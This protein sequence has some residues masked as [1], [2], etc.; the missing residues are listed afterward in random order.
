MKLNLT[1][2]QEM[3]KKTAR[4][5]LSDKCP[6]T[7]V[8]QMEESETGYSIELWQEMAELGWMGLVF[9][10]KYGGGDM[11]F[12]DLAVL[13]EEMG[14]ACLPGPFFSTVVLGGLPILD[15]GNED[16]TWLSKLRCRFSHS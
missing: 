1:E 14:R 8:T 10:E 2:E 12:L 13:L 4:D 11:N 6:K 5:F 9:P 7:F 15:L 3:I 16:R